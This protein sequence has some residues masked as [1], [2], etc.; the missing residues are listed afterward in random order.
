MGKVFIG[1]S[2]VNERTLQGNNLKLFKNL[3]LNYQM[4][5]GVST[6]MY[7]VG[8]TPFDL[9]I[10]PQSTISSGSPMAAEVNKKLVLG[11]RAAGLRSNIELFED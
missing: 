8:F 7:F 9:V 1:K 11:V 6:L 4:R 5:K 3:N 10:N 2:Q